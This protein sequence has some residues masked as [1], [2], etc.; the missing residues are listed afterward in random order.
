MKVILRE[1]RS[2]VSEV[3]GTILILSITVVLFSVVIMWVSSIPTPT[4][5]TRTDIQ[6]AM[7]PVY[8]PLKTETGVFISLTHVGGE[9]LLPF[10]TLIYI[11]DTPPSGTLRSATLTL[12]PF[13]TLLSSPNGIMDGTDNV[14]DI[15]ERWAYESNPAAGWR[16]SDSITVTI[17]DTSRGLIVWSGPMSPTAG[18]RP[19]VFASVWTDGN[20]NTP[21]VDPVQDGLGFCLYA[22]VMDPDLDLNPNSIFANF[23]AFFGIGCPNPLQLNDANQG[24]DLVAGDGVFSVGLTGCM[25]HASIA[26]AGS[27]ILLNATDMRG[28][29]TIYRITLYVVPNTS[30]QINL[31]QIPTQ[32]WQYIGYVQ[33]RTG[34]VWV[35]NLSTPYTSTQTYQPFRVLATTLNSNGGGLF[36]FKM[37]NHG[38]TT[39][40]IDGWTEAFFQNTQSSAGVALYVVAP[41][42]TTIAA[43][44]GGVAAYPG[45]TTNIQ[46]FEY[47][48][49]GN[50]A[51]CTG[52][53]PSVF[54]I[55]TQNQDV[56]G[57]PYTVMVYNKVPF[58]T[59]AP[60]QW[61]SATYFMSV[62]ISG[63]AGPWNYTYSQLLGNGL[64]PAGCTGLGPNYNPHDHLS[65]ANPGC[66]TSWYA[67]VIPFIG[68]VV[69]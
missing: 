21:Q 63:M 67:Q 10:P 37:A 9:A 28:H 6:S 24:Q 53:P 1:D 31:N 35:S 59:G 7:D 43:N 13:N 38:N 65:D 52:Q 33:I 54:D 25:T 23:S 11:T 26:W 50:P 8:G 29:Q 36:H 17:V 32:L 69:Y 4:A 64:N 48:H 20:C 22:K 18:N 66:R 57:T 56:G 46:D 16:T 55:N 15:G 19:P 45:S 12:H 40:F 39:I 30:G 62:L 49:P 44:A 61:K 3:V 42:S 60:N 27:L 14:W 41:C 47:A 58:G 68:M 34:E 5:Q 51:A 2:G